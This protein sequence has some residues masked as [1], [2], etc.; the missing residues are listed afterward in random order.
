MGY[1]WSINLVGA[2]MAR[3]LYIECDSNRMSYSHKDL[4]FH[5]KEADILVVATG[6]IDLVNGDMIKRCSSRDWN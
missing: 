4:T 3:L 5:T 2:P 6:V 1:C